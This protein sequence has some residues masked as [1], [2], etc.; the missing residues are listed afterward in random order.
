M[1][2]VENID[3]FVSI[4]PLWRNQK[5]SAKYCNWQLLSTE[6]SKEGSFQGATDIVTHNEGS[7]LVLFVKCHIT[8]GAYNL[9]EIYYTT[10]FKQSL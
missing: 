10:I 4:L 3:K 1:N 8:F 6:L 2:G 7:K 5:I 9:T